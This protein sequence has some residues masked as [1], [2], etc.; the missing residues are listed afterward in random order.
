MAGVRRVLRYLRATDKLGV[1]ASTD[2]PTQQPQL[3]GYTDSDWAA[4]RD[5]RKSI[6]GYAFLLCGG[7]I[8][9]QAK[10]QQTAARSINGRGQVLAASASPKRWW[11]TTN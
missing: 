9:W 1:H 11:L 8:S 3:I 5:D 6:S 10:K 7:A 2:P 4:D